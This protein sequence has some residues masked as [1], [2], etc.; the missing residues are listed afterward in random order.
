M[1]KQIVCDIHSNCQIFHID[2]LQDQEKKLKCVQSI[3][4]KKKEMSFIYIPQIINVEENLFLDNWPPLSDDLLREKIIQ[5]RNEDK[6]VSQQI[7]DFYEKFTEEVV[8]ILSEKKKE[9]LIQVEKLQQLKDKIINQYCDMASLDKISKCFTQDNE[10]IE[11][12]EKNL[13]ECL[14]S[15]FNRIEEF[16]SILQ[17][18]MRQYELISDKNIQRNT[19]IKENI[20][21]I[22]RIV[23]LLPQNN[24]NFGD[25]MFGFDKIKAYQQ[26]LDQEYEIN[27]KKNSS[28]IGPKGQLWILRKKSGARLLDSQ[29][30][31]NNN[32]IYQNTFGFSISQIRTNQNQANQNADSKVIAYSL[33][34]RIC[35]EKQQMQYTVYPK[36]HIPQFLIY[37]GHSQIKTL[38]QIQSFHHLNL[39]NTLTQKS[40]QLRIITVPQIINVEE[41]LFL[42]NWPPLSDDLLREKIIQLR[43]EDKDV[44]QQIIDFYEK[45][46]EEVV[47][48]LSEK[49]KESLIQVEKL[50]QLKDKI[51]NQY[52]DMASLD[53][54]S[55]CFTQENESIEQIEKNLKE[56]LDSQFNR[57]DEFT[58]ILQQ[59]MRQYELISDVSIQRHTQIKENILNILRI[60]NLL[61]QNNFSFGD[62]MFDFDKISDYQQA[63]DQEYE[64]RQKQNC[65]I[66]YLI[67]QLDILRLN[68]NIITCSNYNNSNEFLASALGLKGQLWIQRVK[69]GLNNVY[70][71]LNYILK[72]KKKYLF[73]INFYKSN[74]QSTFF[75]GLINSQFKD[76]SLNSNG[77]GFS[78][79]QLINLSLNQANDSKVIASTLEFRIC[80][81]KQ[82]MQYS[83]CPSNSNLVQFSRGYQI[84]VNG[85]YYLAFE[86]YYDYL[87]DKLEILDYQELDEFPN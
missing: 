7:I 25:E 74:T 79:P 42:D 71:Y 5:L 12:I 65:Q 2:V 22:L 29:Q 44:S 38:D 77:F 24:F 31:N 30:N 37:Q 39:E 10:S 18:M 64:I 26:V 57:I 23:N 21:N 28:L 48:I 75:I 83:V 80:I 3:A 20:L 16:T 78:I 15:Q 4:N 86:F 81:E 76:S 11:Q 43:N 8:K 27:Q 69:S 54:I 40:P 49:K 36:K 6:D 34:F 9:S 85:S 33:E 47:K 53:K 51:I 58:S 32:S 73:R 50:Q 72:P 45:F 87:G 35:I 55:K 13:K 14:D 60:V 82:Q 62:E 68:P 70:C 61:P 59:M 66:D 46:T 63:I 1:N 17:Q 84:Q 52:C 41:N 19:Q 67:N 56:C